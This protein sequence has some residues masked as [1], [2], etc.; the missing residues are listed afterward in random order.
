MLSEDM[1]CGVLV[2]DSSM[3][4]ISEGALLFAFWTDISAV[5]AE[6]DWM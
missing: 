3:N 1:A 4:D 6:V 5:L 2:I